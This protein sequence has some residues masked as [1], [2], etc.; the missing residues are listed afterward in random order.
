MDRHRDLKRIIIL[1]VALLAIVIAFLV[2]PIPQDP[3]YH[4]FADQ[5]RI[6][7]IPHYWNVVS[8]LPFLAIGLLGLQLV[9]RGPVTG[10]LSELRSGYLLFF[11]GVL[12]IGCGSI[13]YH[14]SPS[15]RTLIWDRLPMT[16]SFMAFF[17]VIVGEN[18]SDTLGRRILWPLLLV[19]IISV[20]YWNITEARGNG[21][22]R[23]Y[24]L[25]QFLPM[26]LIPVILILF[27][28]SLSETGYIWAVLGAYAVSKVAELH[29]EA[30]FR[31]LGVLSGHSL[32]HLFAALGT[33]F[34]LL[35][36]KRRSLI[37]ERA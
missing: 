8:N 30:A 4:N 31:F 18:I 6:L 32:K 35:A 22:L 7:G 16:I 34:F 15:N 27:R 28:P 17:S 36:L 14:L 3:S 20:V 11:L 12:L 21:D 5:R 24:A 9:V 13:Y 2:P 26:L 10:G 33:Y 37:A 19:G 1:G 29:D 25:V 23:P